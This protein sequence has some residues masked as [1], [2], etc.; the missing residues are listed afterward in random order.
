MPFS[1]AYQRPLATQTASESANYTAA[2]TEDG[3]GKK[4]TVDF[5]CVI[6]ANTKLVR[7]LVITP[8]FS[9]LNILFT[10]EEYVYAGNAANYVSATNP[11]LSASIGGAPA[12]TYTL[13]QQDMDA[14]H[15]A[16][17]DARS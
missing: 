12:A 9:S 2:L 10:V 11:A 16:A 3:T 7:K 8:T 4:F 14:F 13:I 15:T 6:G 5:T 17:G 1:L